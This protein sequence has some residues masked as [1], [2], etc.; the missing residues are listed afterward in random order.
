MV[1]V[2]VVMLVVVVVGG[3]SHPHVD[4]GC[5]VEVVVVML[6]LVVV[7]IVVVVVVG[8]L[9]GG[10]GSGPS[11]MVSRVQMWLTRETTHQREGPRAG[12]VG[13][14]ETWPTHVLKK[15]RTLSTRSKCNPPKPLTSWRAKVWHCWR[16]QIQLMET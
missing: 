12:V 11:G 2:V 9:H 16:V 10:C 6:V 8:C 14:D 3:C 15:L 13:R 7:V 1:V 5:R 4:G